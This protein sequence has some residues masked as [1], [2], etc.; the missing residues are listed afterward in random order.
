MKSIDKHTKYSQISFAYS[1]KFLF[2]PETEILGVQKLIW[3]AFKK[4]KP[5]TH[6]RTRECDPLLAQAH[7]KQLY[8][9]KKNLTDNVRSCATAY[10]DSSFL[11]SF[12]LLI[13]LINGYFDFDQFK[14]IMKSK[15]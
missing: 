9:L 6:T 10:C 14:S 1:Q 8:L 5:N 12:F 4:Y 7:H 13:T 3:R 2:Q 11:T 15:F